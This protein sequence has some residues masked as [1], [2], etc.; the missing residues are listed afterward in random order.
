MKSIIV[1]DDEPALITALTHLLEPEGYGVR[2][3]ANGRDALS[4]HEESPADLILSDVM[5]PMLNGHGLV[6]ELRHRGDWTP[7]ILISATAIPTSSVDFVRAIGKPF[8][9]DELL[10]LIRVLLRDHA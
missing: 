6:A 2:P 5:M 9:I 10:D 3:A 1:A 4:L 7:V 8:D